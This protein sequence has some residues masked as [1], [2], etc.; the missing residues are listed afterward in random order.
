[1]QQQQIVCSSEFSKNAAIMKQ[2]DELIYEAIKADEALMIAIGGRVVSTCFEVPPIEDDN[3]PIPNIIITDDGFQNQQTTKDCVWEAAEDRVQVGVD[4]AAASPQEVKALIRMVR[5]AVEQYI[6]TLYT[7]GNGIP[8]LESLSSDGLA[9]DW[10]K[11]CYYQ[12]L[13]YQCIINADDNEQE[14]V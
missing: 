6:G 7:Q 4:V 1:M 8:E 3:T 9:W 11:P 5:H 10:M 14:E 12:R 13:N 2:V